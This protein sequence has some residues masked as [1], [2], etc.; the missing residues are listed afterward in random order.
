MSVV[1]LVGDRSRA[2]VA[3][4]EQLRAAGATVVTASRAAQVNERFDFFVESKCPFRN[5]GVKY[6]WPAVEMLSTLKDMLQD[7]DKVHK[8]GI[9]G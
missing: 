2:P 5:A 1:L 9:Q 3:L 8:G 4:V 7:A 6:K